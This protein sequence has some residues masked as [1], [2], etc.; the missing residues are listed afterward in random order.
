MLNKILELGNMTK[1]TKPIFLENLVGEWLPCLKPSLVRTLNE[2]LSTLNKKNSTSN[3][4]C[5]T[6]NEKVSTLNKKKNR[7]CN[8]SDFEIF[9][10]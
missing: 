9:T 10:T 3:E 1:I 8:F 7:L 5:L 6:L 2:K 4:K